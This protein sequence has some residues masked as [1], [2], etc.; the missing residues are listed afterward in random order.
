MVDEERIEA[1]QKELAGVRSRM[2]EL[3]PIAV[4]T[5]ARSSKKYRTKDGKERVCADSAVLK[6][7]GSGKNLTMRI[8][9]DKERIVRTLLENGRKWRELSKR[10]LLLSS[11]LAVYGALKK[12]CS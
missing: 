5:L 8:P 11:Q 6:F 7:S 2:E 1:M 9:K 4:G 10:H 3:G 12:N